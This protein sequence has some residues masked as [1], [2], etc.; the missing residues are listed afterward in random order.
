MPMQ[1]HYPQDDPLRATP[2]EVARMEATFQKWGALWER[3]G[4]YAVLRDRQRRQERQQA[5]RSQTNR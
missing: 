2:E 1:P 4:R 3:L 5:R